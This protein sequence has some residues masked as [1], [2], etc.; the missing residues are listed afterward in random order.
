MKRLHTQGLLAAV[1]FVFFIF[2]LPLTGFIKNDAGIFAS[3]RGVSFPP[4]TA[5][6]DA[7]ASAV[8]DSIAGKYAF[9][10]IHGLIQKLS[11]RRVIADSEQT[12]IKDNHS[13]LHFET[14]SGSASALVSG[15]TGFYHFLQKQKTPLLYVQAPAKYIPDYTQL[16]AGVADYNN[17][18]ADEAVSGLKDAGITCL[19]LRETLFSSDTQYDTIFYKTDHHWTTPTAFRAYGA[20]SSAAQSIT[21]LNLTLGGKTADTDNY[22]IFTYENFFLG[23]IGKRTGRLYAGI[24]DFKLYLPYDMG[25]NLT[26]TDADGSVITGSF[27]DT[28]LKMGYLSNNTSVYERLCYNVFLGGD[29]AKLSIK[30]PEGTGKILVIKDSYAN[31]VCCFL[32][33]GCAQVDIVDLRLFH[34]NG[35]LLQDYVSA[36]KYDLVMIIYSP[37]AAGNKLLC[38][39]S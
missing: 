34:A 10:E 12:V 35:Y 13:N 5:Q 6:L 7:L 29:F 33:L 14:V 38:D 26:L 27:E 3:M 23:S 31:P 25:K 28:V 11:G 20:I 16:P 21:G 32:S 18:K 39:F 1:C 4:K 2:V 19:D 36:G 15:I 37:G 9:L 24:D 30:N 8:N 17:A 22:T